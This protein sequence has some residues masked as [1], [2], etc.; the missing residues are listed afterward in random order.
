MMANNL[1]TILY[2]KYTKLTNKL[3]KVLSQM[4]TKIIALKIKGEIN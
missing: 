4:K 2:A 1:E 3:I